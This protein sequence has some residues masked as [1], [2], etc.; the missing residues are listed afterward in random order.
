[1]L[2]ASTPPDV[3]HRIGGCVYASRAEHAAQRLAELN[4][5]QLGTPHRA[6]GASEITDRRLRWQRNGAPGDG[7]R[8]NGERPP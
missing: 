4:P 2:D 8:A 5:R 7:P 1:M 6:A 3:M